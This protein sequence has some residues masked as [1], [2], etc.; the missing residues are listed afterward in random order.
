MIDDADEPK[1]RIRIPLDVTTGAEIRNGHA[2]AQLALLQRI[3]ALAAN[4]SPEDVALLASA[5]LTLPSPEEDFG[6]GT[7]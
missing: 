4:A 7:A 2:E 3:R 6:E 1:P 5:Y